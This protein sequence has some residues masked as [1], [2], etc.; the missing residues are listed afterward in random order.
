MTLCIPPST[1]GM[2]GGGQIL[3]LGVPQGVGGAV[4]GGTA[5]SP[6]VAAICAY[7]E[8]L[9]A[10]C[11]PAD[12]KRR[13]GRILQHLHGGSP[14]TAWMGTPWGGLASLMG[15]GARRVRWMR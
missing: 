6:Q 1:L 2:G 14:G 12:A 4:T 3:S 8:L 15:C 13:A 10:E 9:G 5:G 11:M 7:P